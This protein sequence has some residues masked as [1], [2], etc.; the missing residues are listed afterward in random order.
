MKKEINYIPQNEEWRY[1]SY[2]KPCWVGSFG[3][4]NAFGTDYTLFELDEWDVDAYAEVKLKPAEKIFRC[5]THRMRSS[6]TNA[7]PLVKINLEKLLVYFL[8]E[9]AET[10]DFETVGIK[11]NYINLKTICL[12][13]KN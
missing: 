7:K 10:A 3:H 5:E 12:Q 13:K 8:K 2:T 6:Q 4:K 11:I 9:D 1:T